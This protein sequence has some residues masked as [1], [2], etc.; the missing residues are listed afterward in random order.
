M[1]E[2]HA[3]DEHV[4][5][6]VELYHR[7]RW[8]EAAREFR[9][10]LE[11]EPDRGDWQFNLG[12]TLEAAGR[13]AEARAAFEA[14]VEL[15]P[16]DLEPRLAL[17]GVLRELGRPED[18]LAA[19]EAAS[20]IDPHHELSYSHRI[21]TLGRLGRHDEAETVYYLAQQ[22]LEDLPR[23]LKAMGESLLDRGDLD[24]AGWCLRESLRQ[25][26]SVPGVRSRLAEV[27]AATGRPNRAF[28]MFLQEL[29]DDPGGIDTL[30]RF[31]RLLS[32]LGRDA[33]AGEKFRR[34]L[35]L[36]TA[37]AE[38]HWLLGELASRSSR[39]AEAAAEFE[40]AAQL[41]PDRVGAHLKL[42]E[43][44]LHVGRRDEARRDLLEQGRRL[45][46]LAR[47]G[48]ESSDPGGHDRLLGLAA[49]TCE[50]LVEIDEPVAADAVLSAFAPAT[51]LDADRLRLLALARFEA[52]RTAE[53]CACSRRVLRT[54]PNCIA[55]I[56]NLALAAQ[57]GGHRRLA[58]AWWRRG[59][60]I[61]P[62]DEGLRRIRT[63]LILDE[64]ATVI[65]RTIGGIR[66]TLVLLLQPLLRGIR[67][68]AATIGGR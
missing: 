45:S 51:R 57:R 8:T 15:M 20:A 53:A 3:A 34:V 24:R 18:A 21:E 11:L 14:A 60:R 35:E 41:D 29:R 17:G 64:I 48:L 68:M 12:L 40:L 32:E 49:R 13:P 33:E 27:L 65:D 36:D 37:N 43:A 9:R 38:A 54:D 66:T 46:E 56:H 30:I 10:A 5:R 39:H 61:A 55:S 62:E 59:V 4:E 58:W 16:E 22:H 67:R 6:A 1:E 50:L 23:C 63:R 42:A 44:R 19:F 31:G 28:Q 2:W 47:D 7:G 25:D 52:G 26:P